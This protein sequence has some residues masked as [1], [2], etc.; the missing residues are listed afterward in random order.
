[1]AI[2][3]RIEL[4]ESLRCKDSSNFRF[5]IKQSQKSTSSLFC[6][7]LLEYHICIVSLTVL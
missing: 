7:F 2:T 1:M 6:S 4:L 5:L 3:T